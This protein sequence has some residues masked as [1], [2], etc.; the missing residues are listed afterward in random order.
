M[1]LRDFGQV[2]EQFELIESR[3]KTLAL[4]DEQVD[5]LRALGRQLR[6]QAEF[7]R[8]PNDDVADVEEELE[9]SEEPVDRSVIRCVS[10]GHG[11]YKVR[12]ANAIGAVALPGATL[13]VLPKIPV[14]HFA[15]IARQSYSSFRSSHEAV[16]VD[17]L[18]VFWEIVALWCVESVEH[19]VR[20]GL[21]ADYKEYT[22]DLEMVRGRVNV[23]GTTNNFL[24]G[25][26]RAECTFD[27]LD[28]DHPLN[29]ILRAAVRTIASRSS[30]SN[31]ELK[32]RASR[33]D[34]VMEG[35]GPLRHSDLS[36]QIDRR[37][38]RYA[39]AVDLSCRVLGVVGTNVA[40][41]AQFGRTFLIP[42][43][44]LI[45][46][47]VRTV[48]RRSLAP[49]SVTKQGKVMDGD[50]YFSVNPDLVFANGVVTGDVKYKVAT[51]T[52]NRGDVQQASMFA[53]GFSAIAAVI[54]TF[55]CSESIGDL[56]MQ[57]GDVELRRIVWDARA[58]VVPSDAED[59]FVAKV[60]SF[61]A[62]KIP[63]IAVA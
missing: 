36:V 56:T 35:I 27:E 63:L 32:K 43:P 37:T 12:V 30:I 19:L 29:R 4:S 8:S 46:E 48:L 16:S 14:T 55:S 23:R 39:D 61:L 40:T 50:V 47:G 13:H 51:S 59:F 45:E 25:R 17:S 33:L 44:G 54:T 31:S 57:L 26:L 2:S 38:H 10:D 42:T 1:A 6:G 22:D 53:M 24:R 62:G 60:K 3:E 20:Y 5:A 7:Y 58:D 15:H 21:L 41:G 28:I 18:D 34:H 52:W 9:D 11:K 49:V